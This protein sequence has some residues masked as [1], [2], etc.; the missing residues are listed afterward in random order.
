MVSSS[1]AVASSPDDV[2]DAMSPAPTKTS[3]VG[4]VPPGRTIQKSKL[5]VPFAERIA[6]EYLPAGALKVTCSVD[7]GPVDDATMTHALLMNSNRNRLKSVPVGPRNQPWWVPA[8][9]VKGWNPGPLGSYT[10]A[11]GL[12]EPV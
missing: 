11:L 12:T 8:G 4:V 6:Q 3:P 9:T 2:Q 10:C 1:S 7:E 5:P